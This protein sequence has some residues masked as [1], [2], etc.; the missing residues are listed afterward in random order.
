MRAYWE[1]ALDIGDPDV[2]L[3]LATELE[4][5]DAGASISGDLYGEQVG[6]ATAE[7]HAIGINA[8]PAFL[9]DRRL[10]VLGAQ[11]D[12]VFDQVLERL[13]GR[14]ASAGDRADYQPAGGAT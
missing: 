2:L 6:R 13:E 14:S 12:Q 1:E 8:I 5:D 4:L 11:P 7:A 3:T 9:F 10:I